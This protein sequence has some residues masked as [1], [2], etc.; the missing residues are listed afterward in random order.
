MR[1]PA[2]EEIFEDDNENLE[3]EGD[4][5]EN[6]ADEFTLQEF[7]GACDNI[8]DTFGDDYLANML[9]DDELDGAF[10][11]GDRAGRADRRAARA[12][13]RGARS[14]ARGERRSARAEARGARSEARGARRSA[15]AQ[16]RSARKADR[17]AG[18]RG[19]RK[20]VGKIKSVIKS[21]RAK[22]ASRRAKE[23]AI[24]NNPRVSKRIKARIIRRSKV[25][26]FLKAAIQNIGRGMLSQIPGFS[27][28]KGVLKFIRGVRAEVKGKGW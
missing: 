4:D 23:K 13:A 18:R 1:K 26:I 5:Y 10:I 12:E 8:S 28:V 11:D 22:R 6:E 14:E 7:M 21:R 3:I 16:A 9:C 19:V 2:D 25:R 15:R 20:V 17:K 24:L 27:E